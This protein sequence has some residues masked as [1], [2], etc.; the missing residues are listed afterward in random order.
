V[1]QLQQQQPQPSLNVDVRHVAG[2]QPASLQLLGVVDFRP[3]EE[4]EDQQAAEEPPAPSAAPSAVVD[5]DW[6]SV[7][8]ENFM[9]LTQHID[10]DSGLLNQLQSL[11]VISHV[12][13]D[14]IKVRFAR[15][16]RFHA[17]RMVVGGMQR[18]RLCK[19]FPGQF[20]CTINR[21][22]RSENGFV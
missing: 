10:P 11:G 1:R 19:L 9:Q 15:S 17:V 22:R 5:Y 2:D 8:R 12:S 6:K 20:S 4:S 7:I 18:R 14:V 21:F 3:A 13:A 16:I